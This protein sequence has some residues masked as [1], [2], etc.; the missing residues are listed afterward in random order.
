MENAKC[1]VC[2]K[3]NDGRDLLVWQDNNAACVLC[4][5]QALDVQPHLW[6]IIRHAVTRLS[7]YSLCCGMSALREKMNE[8]AERIIAEID[9]HIAEVR[10]ELDSLPEPK[11]RRSRKVQT[12]QR[13]L[14]H[15]IHCYKMTR[16]NWEGMLEKGKSVGQKPDNSLASF[17]RPP[18]PPR[19]V[20]ALATAGKKTQTD[21]SSVP[22]P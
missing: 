4:I 7:E 16:K 1:M 19:L 14:E 5:I 17:F 10:K 21:E 12:R 15:Q 11:N 22:K 6:D 2:R 18:A 8:N 20:Y 9:G 3:G 13:E